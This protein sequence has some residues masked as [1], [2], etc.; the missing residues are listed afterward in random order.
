MVL[1]VIYLSVALSIVHEH[2][3]ES[4]DDD[5]PS[6][7]D[8]LC[9]LLHIHK[10]GNPTLWYIDRVVSGFV[11]SCYFGILGFTSMAPARESTSLPARIITTGFAFFLLIVGA[12]F[13][14]ATAAAIVS[15]SDTGAISSLQD[16]VDRGGKLC[17]GSTTWEMFAPIYR[18]FDASMIVDQ[19]AG[20]GD[21]KEGFEALEAGVCDGVIT[22]EDI[23]R[24]VNSQTAAHCNKMLLPLTIL[25]IPTAWPVRRGIDFELGF[26][27]AERVSVSHTMLS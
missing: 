24:D 25:Q 14:G 18:D 9:A 20:G 15:K 1:L 22:S 5:S 23:V 4:D 17:M 26:M 12:T 21:T 27:M 2:T 7:V 19:T 11:S 10:K 16:V 3:G 6:L 13:T 8:R